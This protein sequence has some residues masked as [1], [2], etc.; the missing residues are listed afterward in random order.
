MA[1]IPIFHPWKH[2]N[3]FGFLVFSGVKN[4]NIAHNWVKLNMMKWRH[5]GIIIVNFE[6]L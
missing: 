3:T 1:N 4:G 5:S 6:H 2:Q